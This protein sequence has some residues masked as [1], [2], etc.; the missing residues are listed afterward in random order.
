MLLRFL[1][2]RPTAALW[3]GGAVQGAQPDHAHHKEHASSKQSPGTGFGD[4]GRSLANI[5]LDGPAYQRAGVVDIPDAPS[6]EKVLV[7]VADLAPVNIAESSRKQNAVW[8][9][10]GPVS[11][12]GVGTVGEGRR[13]EDAARHQC[14]GRKCY[15]PEVPDDVRSSKPYFRKG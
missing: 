12:D 8:Q 5:E 15:R 7:G 9:T 13:A 3:S 11:G 14:P 4:D 6:A 2:S 10:V 1:G